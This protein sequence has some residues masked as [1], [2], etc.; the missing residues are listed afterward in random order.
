MERSWLPL[1]NKNKLELLYAIFLI[2][3]GTLAAAALLMIIISPVAFAICSLFTVI[4]IT[5][6]CITKDIING[7]TNRKVVSEMIKIDIANQMKSDNEKAVIQPPKDEIAQYSAL[8]DIVD[9]NVLVYDYE[10]KICFSDDGINYVAGNVG[11]DLNFVQEPKNEYDNKAVAI[12]LNGRKLGYVYRSDPTQSMINDWIRHGEYFT[13]F[14]NK[15]SPANKTATFKIGF[16]KPL[17]KFPCKIFSL[18]K[19]SKRVDEFSK[20]SENLS[21]CSEGESVSVEYDSYDDTFIVY[22]E[23]YQE[24]GELPKS[25]LNFLSGNEYENIVGII[26]ELEDEFKSSPKAKVKIY[27]VK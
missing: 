20:R 9:E 7:E 12:Y 23:T 6:A 22:S 3:A 2:L 5:L 1:A 14:L 21:S 16:Y 17:T 25:A 10:K 8:P 4:F 18:V 19:T 13:G 11:K 26:E 15:Y 24:I 27:I